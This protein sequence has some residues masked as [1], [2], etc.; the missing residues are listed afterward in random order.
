MD[1]FYNNTFGQICGLLMLFGPIGI[2]GYLFYQIVMDR[3]K[4]E[5]L[6]T[7]ALIAMILLA[8]FT[9]T[10]AII[11]SN[12]DTERLE[13]YSEKEYNLPE[14]ARDIIDN[15]ASN[16]EIIYYT[17]VSDYDRIEVYRRRSN[18]DIF[19]KYYILKPGYQRP[20][21]TN[22]NFDKYLK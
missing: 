10:W 1:F 15:N 3:I 19:Y 2:C 6:A 22:T 14:M 20:E 12:F 17:K 7:M 13:I 9:L 8:L 4:N 21:S 16:I 5:A 18:N 11:Y